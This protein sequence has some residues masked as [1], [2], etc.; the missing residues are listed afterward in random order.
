M[1]LLK[2][3]GHANRP[4]A[5][6]PILKHSYI[7]SF[8]RLPA[9]CVKKWGS[10]YRGES[11]EALEE[12]V[13]TLAGNAGARS[14]SRTVQEHL[15]ELKR[16]WKREILLLARARKLTGYDDWPVPQHQRDLVFLSYRSVVT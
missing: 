8:R 12:L 7:V 3:V 5:G 16:F 15:D 9:N 14:R 13:L 6:K 4:R 2:F 11:S 1:R 10:F